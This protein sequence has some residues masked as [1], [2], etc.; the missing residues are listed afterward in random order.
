[1]PKYELLIACVDEPEVHRKKEGDVVAVRPYPFVWGT[2]EVDQYFIVII[3]A[4]EDLNTLKE[5]YQAPL[6]D[7]MTQAEVDAEETANEV[8]C[9]RL[10][11]EAIAELGNENYETIQEIIR[12]HSLAHYINDEGFEE[13]DEDYVEFEWEEL[14]FRLID[15]ELSS[16]VTDKW[17]KFLRDTRNFPVYIPPPIIGKNQFKIPLDIIK[18]G[19]MPDLDLAKVRDKTKVYQ[20]LKD[21]DMVMD[22]REQVSIIYDKYKRSFKYLTLRVAEIV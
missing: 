7:G 15:R 22:T 1:M 5:K 17:I 6:Y 8:E 12:N 10:L 4:D 18:N 16:E 19:W 20:P 21:V 9:R 14:I 3:E 2:K 13:S 11:S